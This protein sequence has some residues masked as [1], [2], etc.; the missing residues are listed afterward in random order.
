M[1]D[2]NASP[3]KLC[4]DC[5]KEKP[6]R[7]FWRR[8]QSPDGLALY[9]KTCFGERNA[10]AYRGRIT[11]EG[12]EARPYRRHSAVPEGMKY[13]PQCHKIKSV[14]AFGSNRANASGRADYCRPCH[15]RVMAE[16]KVRKHG[17]QR[18]Y[19]L[20]LRYGVTADEVDAIR[21]RQGGVCVIC[22]RAAGIH[23][24]HDHDTGLIRWLLCFSCNGALG[25]FDDE[26][27]RLRQAAD[28]LEGGLWHCRLLELE[29]GVAALDGFTRRAERTRPENAGTSRHYRLRHRYG[30]SGADEQ[31][32]I[33]IQRSLCAICCN[34]KAEHIDHDHETGRVRGVLCPGCNSGMGQLRDDPAALRRA[35]DYL[36]GT[37]VETRP[38]ADGGTRLSFTIPDVDP[39]TVIL[40]GWES[41]RTGDGQARKAI[42][43]LQ[44]NMVFLPYRSVEFAET[45]PH[46]P[47]PVATG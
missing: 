3:S 9:C 8:K 46:A 41:Y 37:L 33:A 29:L 32:M 17:G 27:W 20:K 13:C 44:E 34:G 25:Q 45:Y 40:D 38:A 18:N 11:K 16:I 2:I 47:V 19:L 22:L 31:A 35:A 6:V 26:P 23:V 24:D 1:A 21:E 30:I 5:G 43:A 14:E 28:Y 39:A 7:E 42:L 12:K 15:N 4:R 36:S 10:D